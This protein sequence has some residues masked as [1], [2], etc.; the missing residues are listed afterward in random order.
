MKEVA[1][2]INIVIDTL[3]SHVVAK[4]IHVIDVMIHRKSSSMLWR[5][6]KMLFVVSAAMNRK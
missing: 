3:D 4:H 5:W 6:L 1:N 2:I